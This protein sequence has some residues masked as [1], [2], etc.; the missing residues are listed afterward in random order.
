MAT[1]NSKTAIAN[2]ALGHLKVA[3]VTSIDPP[4][5]DSKAAKAAAKWYDQA[6]RDTLEGH[7]WNFASKRITLGSD[8]TAPLFEY[9]DRYQV[10][11]DFIRINRIGLSWYDPL[12][13]FEVEGDYILANESPELNLV[14]VSNISD[15]SKFSPKYITALSYRLAAY[16]AYEI[17]GNASL[18][19][20]M[21]AQAITFIIFDG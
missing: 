15:T 19:D 1:P 21:E 2:L 6:R 5:A 17:T 10:P 18:V 8:T 4:D 12:Q 16:M 20:V 9:T 13:D 14:Y 11:P 3:P 7:P